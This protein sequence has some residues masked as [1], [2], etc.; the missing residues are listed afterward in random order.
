[1]RRLTNHQP[2]SEPILNPNLTGNR[3][4]VTFAIAAQA[5]RRTAFT[6]SSAILAHCG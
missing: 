2:T 1:M 3:Q 4:A 5:K 6:T